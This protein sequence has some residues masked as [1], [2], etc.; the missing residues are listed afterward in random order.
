[1]KIYYKLEIRYWAVELMQ[2]QMAYIYNRLDKTLPINKVTEIYLESKE[3]VLKFLRRFIYINGV[4][5]CG[6][7]GVQERIAKDIGMIENGNLLEE[8]GIKY[9]DFGVDG[10]AVTIS[11]IVINDLSDFV[12]SPLLNKRV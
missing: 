4:D 7:E 1:M 8:V 2:E 10:R 12:D 5:W 9:N 11:R 6:E 3:D